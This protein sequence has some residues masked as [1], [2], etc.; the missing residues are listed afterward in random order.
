MSNTDTE[1]IYEIRIM[2]ERISGQEESRSSI[3]ITKFKCL[4][5][6]LSTICKDVSIWFS[7]LTS[8]A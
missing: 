4:T 5:K 6:I 1:T 2:T 8:E 3:E 7:K